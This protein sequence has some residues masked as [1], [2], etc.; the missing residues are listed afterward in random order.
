MP[1][2]KCANCGAAVSAFAR[3]CPAC[4][5]PNQP[6][7][8]T[9][10]AALA[11][12]VMLG[13]AVYVGARAF[14]WERPPST[15]TN[16]PQTTT[17]AEPTKDDYGW[18]VQAMAECDVY[19]KQNADTLY[20]LIIPLARSGAFVVGWDPVAMGRIGPSV[21]LVSSSDALIG[22]RNGVFVLYRKPFTF[23]V[24]DA[25]TQTVYKWKPSTGV[26]ELKSRE[27]GYAS[28]TLGL[29][30]GDSADIEWGP[31]FTI[32]KGTCYWTNPVILS[33]PSRSAPPAPAPQ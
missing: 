27:S 9:T 22:L 8:V 28:L 11:L 33:A 26:S 31:T 15:A 21:T 16:P 32:V 3:A 14:P 20:F 19:A 23:A 6:N 25:T 10:I 12:L 4:G 2:G 17:T 30:V 29:Q 18:L 7:I 13:G 1:A 24:K 5:L